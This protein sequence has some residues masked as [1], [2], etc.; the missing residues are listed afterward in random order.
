MPQLL[1]AIYTNYS[2]DPVL[3]HVWTF[4]KLLGA[5]R[6]VEVIEI[7]ASSHLSSISPSFFNSN[8]ASLSAFIIWYLFLSVGEYVGEYLESP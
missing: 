6:T 5:F 4:W 7:F 8:C 2:S 3:P 1:A